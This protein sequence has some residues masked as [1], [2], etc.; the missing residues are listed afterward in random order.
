MTS[1]FDVRIDRLAYGGDA[2][3]RLPDGR[4]VFVPYVIPGELVRLRVVEDKPQ[5]CNRGLW[6]KCWNH[7]PTG[8]SHGVHI[9]QPAEAAIT[10]R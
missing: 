7:R 3:G 8:L 2:I 10:N 4:V 5:R 1:T 9:F 6:W